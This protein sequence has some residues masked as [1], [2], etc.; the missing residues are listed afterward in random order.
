MNVRLIG[1]LLIISTLSMVSC[2]SNSNVMGRSS[3]ANTLITL[4]TNKTEYDR[5]EK[6]IIRINNNSSLPITIEGERLIINSFCGSVFRKDEMQN[7]IR[8]PRD[9]FILTVPSQKVLRPGEHHEY[10]Y[11]PSE[12]NIPPGTYKIGIWQFAQDERGCI[13]ASEQVFSNEFII[14]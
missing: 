8:I 11:D 7:W 5:G 13:Y 1:A 12:E 14:R 2:V 4:V 10:T 9:P 3:N 6:V